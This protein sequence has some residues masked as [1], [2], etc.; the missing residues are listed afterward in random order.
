MSPNRTYPGCQE[1]PD[2]AN[3]N[4]RIRDLREDH[5][6][7][8]HLPLLIPSQCPDHQLVRP[9]SSTSMQ[10]T[11]VSVQASWRSML[12]PQRPRRFEHHPHTLVRSKLPCGGSKNSLRSTTRRGRSSSVWPRWLWWQ[13]R[14]SRGS[15]LTP[16]SCISGHRRLINVQLKQ[17]VTGVACLVN[18]RF[19]SA[20][21]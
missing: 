19:E 11:P 16:S 20:N 10:T 8:Q 5:Q 4:A 14:G 13:G 7:T 12:P 21:R 6:K 9:L 18:G 17:V 15:I 1:T 2:N 3:R